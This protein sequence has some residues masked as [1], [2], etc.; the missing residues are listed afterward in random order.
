MDT[1]F[2]NRGKTLCQGFTLIE[3]IV[4]VTIAGILAAIAIPSFISTI[5]SNRLTTYTNDFVT[6]L[7]FARSEAIKRGQ[8][9]T[10]SRRSATAGTWE[11]GW[12][13]FVDFDANNALDEGN[14][15]TLCETNTDGSPKEDCLL[16]T[17]AALSSG[18]TL[19]NPDI[20]FQDFVAYLPSG[21]RKIVA[22]DTG[23]SRFRV[24][25]STASKTNSRS[26]T[27][28]AAG[29]ASVSKGTSACP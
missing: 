2:M 20:P 22:N 29:R 19:R 18:Y 21:L 9:V 17:Q 24:C 26:I 27:L 7:N 6:A 25:D 23:T 10:V 1:T 11:G 8:Q 4:T 3:L 28:N 5:N 14:N 15:A 16:K 13:V 12:N